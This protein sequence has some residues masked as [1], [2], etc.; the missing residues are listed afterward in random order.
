MR[1]LTSPAWLTADR[2]GSRKLVR[3]N[4]DPEPVVG[5]GVGGDVVGGFV[6]GVAAGLAHE[7]GGQAEAEAGEGDAE[8]ERFG[9]EPGVSAMAPVASAVTATRRRSRRLR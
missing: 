9:A 7:Q 6:A 8:E 3:A 2:A 4:I 1:L 5:V